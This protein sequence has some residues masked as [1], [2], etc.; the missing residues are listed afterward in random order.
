[1]AFEVK[2]INPIDRQPRKAVGVQLPFSAKSVFTSN[3]QTKDSIK[4][5]LINFFLTNRGER[6]MN[7]T[8]GSILREKLFQ[9]INSELEDEIDGL[10]AAALETY[11]PNVK[12]IKM[13]IASKP[14]NNLIQFYLSYE[15]VNTNIKDELLINI[16]Q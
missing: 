14:D 5:N 6:Y 11:F 9:N 8:F 10:V 2:K 16:E 15:I 13:Q 7:P 4:N 12:A 3:Y 1:M